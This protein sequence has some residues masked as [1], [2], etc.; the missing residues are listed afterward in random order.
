MM[1]E[2]DHRAWLDKV[3]GLEMEREGGARCAV[4]FEYNLRR[5]WLKAKELGIGHFTTTLTVSRFKNS[6][7]IFR[8]GDGFTGFEEI[9][10]KKKDGFN[11]SIQLS[12]ELGLYRQHYCGCEFS[13]RD[14]EAYERAKAEKAAEK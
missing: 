10:F 2:Q 4:C 14:A 13:L 12:K 7:V 6:N 1:E 11:R 5:A 3:K 8:V 9:N